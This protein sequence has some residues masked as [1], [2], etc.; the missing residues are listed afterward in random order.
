MTKF[1]FSSDV[2]PSDLPARVRAQMW[3]DSMAEIGL[4]FEMGIVASRRFRGEL[5]VLPLEQVHLGASLTITDGSVTTLRTSERIAE[6]NDNRLII[7]INCGDAPMLMRQVGRQVALQRGEM[8][9]VAMDV[10]CEGSTARSGYLN[11][12][13]IPREMI[14]RAGQVLER[15]AAT[16]LMMDPAAQR[17]LSR[18]VVD[19]LDDAVTLDANIKAAAEQF[20]IRLATLMLRLPEEAPRAA[21]DTAFRAHLLDIRKA[22]AKSYRETNLTVKMVGKSVGLSS[23]SIQHVLKQEGTTFKKE[24]TTIRLQAAF[25][26]LK[27]GSNAT[28]ADIAFGCGFADLSTFHRAFRARYRDTPNA[29]RAGGKRPRTA[30][31]N[32]ARRARAG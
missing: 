24:L 13:L 19:L 29:L 7:I 3:A 15:Y 31:G 22:I 8:T 2:L 18:H 28:V 26:A 16:R 32:R 17:L 12:V 30:S 21:P 27:S 14:P 6:D 1:T 5:T 10:P 25:A 9:V 11:F 4:S 23:R 20:I